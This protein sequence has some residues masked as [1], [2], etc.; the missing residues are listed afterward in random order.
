MGIGGSSVSSSVNQ[1]I[2]SNS[3][4]NVILDEDDGGSAP[5]VQVT[6]IFHVDGYAPEPFVEPSNLAQAD[7]Y[8]RG[9][10]AEKDIGGLYGGNTYDI[11]PLSLDFWPSH[12]AS[13]RVRGKKNGTGEPMDLIAPYSK[14]ILEQVSEGSAE[15]AQ[16]VETFGDF[17]VFLFGTRPQTFTYSG[18]LINTKNVNW[19]S[20]FQFYYDNYLKGT[21]CVENDA[22]LILTY[23]GRQVEGYILGMN[24]VTDAAIEA[25]VKLS[26]QV[27]ILG[28]KY[29]G[30]SEDF[31][32]FT[33]GSFS[34][35]YQDENF[36]KLIDNIA[37]NEG[38]GTA[39]PDYDKAYNALKVGMGGGD[40]Q[41]PKPMAA[42]SLPFAG[43]VA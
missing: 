7:Y 42:A 37:G 18:T 19:Y 22:T 8:R 39:N 9:K 31:G 4:Q 16:I 12:E 3:M 40:P 26:F 23:G 34:T 17:Y 25:G 36:K 20:D 41:K 10:P 15:R 14:F 28:R 30:F 24:T 6:K 27:L 13:I 5:S 2:T 33:K 11:V 29:L 32:F 38:N 43:N 35:L 21:R 1:G